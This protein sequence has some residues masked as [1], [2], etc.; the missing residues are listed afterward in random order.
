MV[1]R[2]ASILDNKDDLVL[3]ITS[4]RQLLEGFVFVRGFSLFQSN[5]LQSRM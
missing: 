5:F 2:E 4:P 3:N 1:G